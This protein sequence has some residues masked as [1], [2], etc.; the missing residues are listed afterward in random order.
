MSTTSAQAAVAAKKGASFLLSVTAKGVTKVAEGLKNAR[1]AYKEYHENDVLTTLKKQGVAPSELL[2]AALQRL[3]YLN[4]AGYKQEAGA[5]VQQTVTRLL[6]TQKSSIPLDVLR[7]IGQTLEEEAMKY[8]NIAKSKFQQKLKQ[9]V[10][11]FRP[12]AENKERDKLAHDFYYG[13]TLLVE[14]VG[15]GGGGGA[16]DAAAARVQE[17][18]RV[19]AVRLVECFS[20][21]A[22]GGA[23]GATVPPLAAPNPYV[24]TGE[25]SGGGGGHYPVISPPDYVS[26]TSAGVGVPVSSSS[27]GSGQEAG[28]EP[29]NQRMKVQKTLYMLGS[30]LR[31]EAEAA[32]AKRI[33]ALK[34]AE[35][36]MKA[37]E[38]NW[39]AGMAGGPA[40]SSAGPTGGAA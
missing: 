17:V 27:G 2:F 5:V 4:L 9:F 39:Q 12:A 38:Q 21:G 15:A 31:K 18:V 22:A 33:K 8:G 6:D 34:E 19:A 28:P 24:M 37:A 1:K 13:V 26:A 40:A 25:V 29:D 11:Q 32:E 20:E 14:V 23:T 30:S 35:A 10:E 3:H 36:M 7:V 16:E